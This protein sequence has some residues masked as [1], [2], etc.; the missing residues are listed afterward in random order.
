MEGSEALEIVDQLVE[1][2]HPRVVALSIDGNESRAGRSG[3]RFKEAFQRAGASG[4]RRTVHA[5]ES[6]GPEGVW[7]AIDLL[8]AERIDHGVRAIEEPDLVK[9]LIDRGIALDMCPGTNITIGLYPDRSSHPFDELRKAGV[10][11]SVNTDDPSYQST[12]LET[13]YA[14]TADAYGWD[15]T[16]LREVAENSIKASF[17]NDDLKRDLLTEVDA[18]EGGAV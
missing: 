12:N 9:T 2:H 18:W 4:L 5:G 13:E 15:T 8:G 1:L 7:D 11:V 6:S 10:T 16:T 17:A 3:P 14:V